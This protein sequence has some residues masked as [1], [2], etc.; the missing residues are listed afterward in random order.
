[1]IAAT[2]RVFKWA[3]FDRPPL[4]TWTRGRV[5]SLGDAAHPMLPYMAQGASQSIED[6]FVLA[7]CL[8]ADRDDP[9]RAIEAYAALR[10]DRTAAVQTASRDAG[11]LVHLTDPAE[12]Q[13]RNARLSDNP[14]APIA[15]FDWIW[16][17]DPE[18]ATADG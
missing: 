10:R 14:E 18:T 5:T 9:R 7:R 12:V 3:L 8:A 6:A 4:A 17:Y 16:S 1:M 13:A 15:R 11:R 2:E